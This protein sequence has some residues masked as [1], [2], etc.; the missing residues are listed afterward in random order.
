MIK[1][2]PLANGTKIRNKC[3]E[4]IIT[5]KI[6]E[7]A[8]SI[9][10]DA[11]LIKFDSRC[12]K[13][14]IKECFPL[15]IDYSRANGRI[16]CPDNC[17]GKFNKQKGYF[18]SAYDK[19]R[20]L[21]ADE[22]LTNYIVRAEDIF[23]ANNTVYSVFAK[24]TGNDYE[25]ILRN[26]AVSR[27]NESLKNVFILFKSIAYAIMQFH[28]KDILCLDIK[29][30][31]I[32]VVEGEPMTVKLF[33]FD[34][35]A[36]VESVKNDSLEYISYSNG[37]ATP[38]QEMGEKSVISKATDIYTFGAMMY[39]V[40]FG[41]YYNGFDSI[42]G[43]ETDYST[44]KF[45]E[46][47]NE[48]VDTLKDFFEKTLAVYPSDR[49]QS[50][51]EI[52]TH[53][54]GM[55]KYSDPFWLPVC[56]PDV[57]KELHDAPKDTNFASFARRFVILREIGP[58]DSS[59]LYDNPQFLKYVVE[60]ATS[61]TSH[62]SDFYLAIW[63]A[64][65]LEKVDKT[66][67]NNKKCDELFEEFLKLGTS[68]CF[69]RSGVEH[70]NEYII[71]SINQISNAE[72]VFKYMLKIA[73]I[74][75]YNDYAYEV[76]DCAIEKVSENTE[77]YVYLMLFG[78]IKEF[79][80]RFLPIEIDL[81]EAKTRF[82]EVKGIY[83]KYKEMYGSIPFVEDIIE[84]IQKRCGEFDDNSFFFISANEICRI[85]LP[86]NLKDFQDYVVGL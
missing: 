21:S 36:T 14:R 46:Y 60:N 3:D 18:S 54:D 45:P 29:P 16:E 66:T 27:C 31:N 63:A 82:N 5:E 23:E 70:L 24:D 39:Y 62:K 28:N 50:F 76:F 65:K 80:T 84:R 26:K 85:E 78:W 12:Y 79:F 75:Y 35:F 71:D 81:N 17:N 20:E 2:E 40:L 69:S 10:Y 74:E 6:G 30:Q 83:N 19:M 51:N 52:I 64:H 55:I 33:D 7:G 8:S 11:D 38:E 9:V 34:S 61:S 42:N 4:Y 43:F 67:K 49:E 68:E 44:M 77:Y 53:L 1:R 57:K 37:F 47:K 15:N 32:L 86:N 58:G 72:E 13:V 48:L 73:H 59:D 41:R 22:A 56:G 25:A